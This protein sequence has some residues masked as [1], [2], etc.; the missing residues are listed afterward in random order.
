MVRSCSYL[1][2][3]LDDELDDNLAN[4]FRLHLGVC[5]RCAAELEQSILT[6]ELADLA[7]G[8]GHRR[9]RIEVEGI[10]PGLREDLSQEAPLPRRVGRRRGT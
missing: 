4:A 1:H 8:V 9:L 10:P 6:D 3:F 7:L 2:P 5:D